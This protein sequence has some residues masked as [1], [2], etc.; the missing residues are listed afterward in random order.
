MAMVIQALEGAPGAEYQAIAYDFAIRTLRGALMSDG[1]GA[2]GHVA[3]EAAD[4]EPPGS[5]DETAPSD[6]KGEK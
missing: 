1:A 5:G 3:D 4:E 2:A 6:P